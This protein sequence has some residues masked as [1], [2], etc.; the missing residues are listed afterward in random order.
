MS[1]P[2]NWGFYPLDSS[3]PSPKFIGTSRT[4]EVGPACLHKSSCSQRTSRQP[5]PRSWMAHNSKVKIRCNWS[6]R[7]NVE[8][9]RWRNYMRNN[10][11]W[12]LM[13]FF[14]SNFATADTITLK[15]GTTRS[16][17]LVSVKAKN[18][19]FREGAKTHLYLKTDIQSI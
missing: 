5:S 18:I 17:T 1:F 19:G 9:V 15:D 6:A 7:S 16:G 14:M 12:L 10:A 2:S 11:L 3:A 4:E 8:T 13:L